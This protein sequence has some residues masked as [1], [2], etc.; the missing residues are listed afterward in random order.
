MHCKHRYGNMCGT[1]MEVQCIAIHKCFTVK[2]HNRVKDAYKFCL[3]MMVELL[4]S[5][6][7]QFKFYFVQL[8][9]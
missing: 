5:V 1:V 8:F 6:N 3:Y 9:I 2:Q 4:H 7:V